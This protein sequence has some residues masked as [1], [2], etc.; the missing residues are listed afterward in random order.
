M[1]LKCSDANQ[2]N[3]YECP[4]CKWINHAN[5]LKIEKIYAF[6]SVD[7]KDKNEGVVGIPNPDGKGIVPMIGAD[8]NRV[9]FLRPTAKLLA[10]RTGM[11]IQLCEF[12]TKTVLETY[13]K[14]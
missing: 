3:Y 2:I 10:E 9:D 12:S 5:H 1:V 6:I 8:K 11:K 14:E 13:E 4:K 7:L